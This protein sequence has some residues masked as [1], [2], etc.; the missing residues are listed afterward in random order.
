MRGGGGAAGARGGLGDPA[1]LAR[2]G[3]PGRARGHVRRAA[4]VPAH[5][6]RSPAPEPGTLPISRPPTR[7]RSPSLRQFCRVWRRPRPRTSAGPRCPSRSSPTRRWP[8]P[9]PSAGR[10]PP[11][12]LLRRTLPL[13]P[14]RRARTVRCTSSRT[15]AWARRTCTTTVST[16]AMPA[17]ASSG[18][19]LRAP[20]GR[21]GLRRQ[22]AT[23]PGRLPLLG[24]LSAQA[25]RKVRLR[26]PGNAVLAPCADPHTVVGSLRCSRAHHRTPPRR[27][28][29]RL[30]HRGAAGP[31]RHGR[32]LPGRAAALEAPGRLEAAYAAAGPGRTLPPTVPARVGV[33]RL[34]RPPER[35]SHLRRRRGRGNALH[36]HAL[37]GGRTAWGRCWPRRGRS[38]PSGRSRYSARSRPASTPPTHAGSSTETSNP[39]TSCWP[40]TAPSVSDFGLTR[41]AQERWHGGESAPL[42]HPRLPRSRTNRRRPAR[43]CRRYL[44]LGCVLYHCL[45]DEPPFG[46]RTPDGAALGPFNEQPPIAAPA[47]ARAARSNRP[48]HRHGARQGACRRA[49]RAAAARG[50]P[51]TR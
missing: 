12:G 26:P 4:P 21:G 18:R 7:R 25:G 11:I 37:R 40:R 22:P 41:S 31:R 28:A 35:G 23:P 51:R 34:A 5:R 24:A 39:P 13:T 45:A 44:R 10:R 1:G 42:R 33:R 14:W 38:S 30:P 46:K 2:G 47:P 29:G 16:S 8:C 27:R 6:Q 32:R 48:R 36:R 49:T 19:R 43:P 50:R 20:A 17:S 3:R 9:S 15:Q